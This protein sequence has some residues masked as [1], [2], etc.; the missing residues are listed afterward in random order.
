[1][2]SPSPPF[3]VAF[4]SS[5]D[6]DEN[7]YDVEDNDIDET[8]VVQTLAKVQERELQHQLQNQL[9]QQQ[10]IR[11]LPTHSAGTPQRGITLDDFRENVNSLQQ[12]ASVSSTRLPAATTPATLPVTT[13]RIRYDVTPKPVPG[14]ETI[15]LSK[16]NQTSIYSTPER[17]QVSSESDVTRTR[18]YHTPPT[19]H[20]SPE[21]P[22]QPPAPMSPISKPEH[23]DMSR[24]SSTPPGADASKLADTVAETGA[25]EATEAEPEVKVPRSSTR[26][27]LELS[28]HELAE[29]KMFVTNLETGE[30]VPIDQ[31]EQ[32]FPEVALAMTLPES[33]DHSEANI[34]GETEGKDE[35]SE[36]EGFLGFLSNLFKFGR[37]SSLR[38]AGASN[39]VKTKCTKKASSG[40]SSLGHS[41]VGST[42]GDGSSSSLVGAP[43]LPA[44]VQQDLTDLKIIQDMQFHHG[45]PW[46]FAWSYC[47]RF[48]ATAGHD[49][50]LAVWAV[51][52]TPASDE[53]DR[54]NAL[55]SSA[56]QAAEGAS[57]A[58]APSTQA[59]QFSEA[60]PEG[61]IVVNIPAS[62]GGRNIINPTP[63]LLLSGHRG[64]VVDLAWSRANFI[65]TASID[66]TVRL[67]H[68]TRSKCLMVFQHADFVTSIAFHPIED[69]Y[70][71]S[72]SFDR[73]LRVWSIPTNEVVEWVQTPHIITAVAWS[74][75]GRTIVAGLY[76]GRVL[77]YDVDQLR[78]RTQL[79]CR[80][81]SGR[82]SQGKK[83]TG[84]QFSP[85]GR[86]LLVTTNDSRIRLYR[87]DDYSMVGKFK[88]LA[89][90]ELQ[91][92]AT[93]SQDGTRII[94]GSEQDNVYIW[95]VVTDGSHSEAYESFRA[96]SGPVT[97]AQFVPRA[98][99]L[100]AARGD[101][102]EANKV[103]QLILTTGSTGEMR[104][105][106]N[107]GAPQPL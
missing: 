95:D 6:D 40:Q 36:S 4:S 107:R 17:T 35:K 99:I 83:V 18:T 5:G 94:C 29:M 89:N 13:T 93:F 56:R 41:R 68:L 11:P 52:G 44:R 79:E 50:T 45:P 61:A 30:R 53:I 65:L 25:A 54:R 27:E 12:D 49:T 46:A 78:Y 55:L 92:R 1:M 48:L 43:T 91:I 26:A 64:D 60:S 105:F 69:R 42:S 103:R 57:G 19:S 76:N 71:V 20:A 88:G 87:L 51:T 7:F 63:Y 70:F 96:H 59:G 67:W 10:P 62:Q 31:V 14:S 28:E 101:V 86:Y 47:G 15:N 82:Y 8:I 100:A 66:R 16:N 102:E 22:P 33:T 75:D 37:P 72:G 97:V 3:T 77:V 90:S 80:N 98:T 21:R 34:S 106:E 81:R 73:K 38:R 74:P 9:Q 85:D 84:L 23:S 58:P 39:S 24:G 32:A 2:R 104:F